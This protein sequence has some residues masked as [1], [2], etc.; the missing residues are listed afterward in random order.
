MTVIAWD[1][2]LLA[3]DRRMVTGGV[4]TE[5]KKI[6]RAGNFLV[7]GAGP[8]AEVAYLR[9]WAENDFAPDRHPEKLYGV[10][11]SD[12]AALL[13]VTDSIGG[14]KVLLFEGGGRTPIVIESPFFALGSGEKFASAAMYLGHNAE[15]AVSVANALCHW[16]GNGCDVLRLRS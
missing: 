16:C 8:A 15:Y 9:E 1:G 2:S 13:A 7:G 6:H 10:R 4:V 12:E 3:A 11:L 14:P 5:V